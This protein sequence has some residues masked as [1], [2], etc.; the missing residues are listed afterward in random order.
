MPPHRPR[1]R[2]F[3]KGAAAGRALEALA[4]DA[5]Q[6]GFEPDLTCQA[7]RSFSAGWSSSARDLGREVQFA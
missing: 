4:S 7:R 2:P 1:P 5:L 3:C 6:P